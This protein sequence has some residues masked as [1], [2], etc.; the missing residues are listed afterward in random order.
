MKQLDS[1]AAAGE[2]G[3]G[4]G[5]RMQRLARRLVIVLLAAWLG[6]F[7]ALRTADLRVG[8][9]LDDTLSFSSPAFALAFEQQIP[10][11]SPEFWRFV[12][13][14]FDL[15]S[16]KRLVVGIAMAAKLLGFR[17]E[18]MTAS[19]G[20]GGGALA[21]H[22]S[23]LADEFHFEWDKARILESKR[24]V[25]FFGDS[26]SDIREAREAGVTPIRVLRSP[27]S[28]R[29]GGVNPGKYGEW[30]LPFSR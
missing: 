22:W 15:E 24:F 16:P 3:P 6:A 18:R 8:F 14:R 19:K 27:L 5:G 30:V 23:W 4:P 17:I 26:D 7:A 21:G 1:G 10:K 12:N 13:A 29:K 28:T 2:G 25:L 11:R 20:Y 9:D